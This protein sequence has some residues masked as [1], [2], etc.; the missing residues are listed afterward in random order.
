M[1]NIL[2]GIFG[3][4]SGNAALKAALPGGLHLEMAPQGTAM[5][6]ATFNVVS[7]RPEYM[8][9]GERDEVVWLQFD[10]W[11]STNALRQTAYDALL[12]VYDDARIAATGYTPVILERINQ[13]M[14]R[15]GEQSEIFRAIIEYSGRWEK[16]A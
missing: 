1:Q 16:G 12:A 8:L 11:A 6:Y 13:Q 2:T 15:D 4:Y 14:V 10:I 3:A 5:T 7:A 9:A